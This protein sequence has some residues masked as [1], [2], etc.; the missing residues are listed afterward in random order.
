MSFPIDRPI[1]PGDPAPQL[2]PREHPA[3][4]LQVPPNPGQRPWTGGR[5]M[6][7]QQSPGLSPGEH[8]SLERIVALQKGMRRKLD[9]DVLPPPPP[10]RRSRSVF[11][12]FC[13]MA[14]G[15]LFGA[16]V[17][18]VA[19]G[20]FTVSDASNEAAPADRGQMTAVK[21]PAPQAAI[22]FGKPQP[23]RPRLVAEGASAENGDEVPLGVRVEGPSEGVTALVRGLRNGTTLSAG[24]L[25]ADGG[26]LVPA[27][28]L[29][30]AAI[31]PPQGFSGTMEYTIS[32]RLADGNVVDQQA[33]RLDW[34]AAPSAE[35]PRIS[36]QL[37]Q[38]EITVLLRRGQQLFETGDL[39]GARLLLQRAADAGNSRAAFALGASYDP[40]VLN[41]LGVLGVMADV[42]KARAWYEKAK[43]YGSADAPKRLELLV[44]Q[45]R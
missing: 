36:R 7:V 8:E 43:E 34:A 41:D 6:T 24:R 11:A 40:L 18:F 1:H 30:R 42:A 23:A 45:S 29:A 25:S 10:A 35:A 39:A 4:D 20:K 16:L 3:A 38:E 13:R 28:E 21:S 44:S 17:T 33:M 19:L 9:P 5:P 32:L 14:I 27:A 37:D 26:W 12:L 15:V 31:R 22:K 2:R